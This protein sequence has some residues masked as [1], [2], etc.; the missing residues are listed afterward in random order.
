MSIDTSSF[1]NFI[2]DLNGLD[3]DIMLEIKDKENSA[4]KAVKVLKDYKMQLK[5]GAEH[6]VFDPAKFSDLD[7]DHKAWDKK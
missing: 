2:K 7:I 5:A 4:L 1:K 6:P 3:F